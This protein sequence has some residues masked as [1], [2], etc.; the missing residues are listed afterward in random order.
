MDPVYNV[1]SYPPTVHSTAGLG[2]TNRVWLTT[3]HDLPVSDLTSVCQTIV[4][5][6]R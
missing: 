5:R 4:I 6:P 1:A 3:A 2:T